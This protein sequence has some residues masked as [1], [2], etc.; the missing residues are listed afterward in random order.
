MLHLCFYVLWTSF[1]LYTCNNTVLIQ[2]FLEEKRC[3]DKQPKLCMTNAKRRRVG[4]TFSAI[5]LLRCQVEEYCREHSPRFPLAT[6]PVASC[7]FIHPQTFPSEQA[8]SSGKASLVQP[9][10]LL[11]PSTV[12][13]VALPHFPIPQT[14]SLQ[15]HTFIYV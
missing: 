4:Q 9:A 1:F 12:R 10:S 3:G 5:M 13:T 15:K 14:C 8:P 7:T 2:S 6:T 11:S